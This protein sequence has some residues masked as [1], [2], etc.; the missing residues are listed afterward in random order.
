MPVI[1]SNL[2]SVGY[3]PTTQTLEIEPLNGTIYQYLGVRYQSI[4]A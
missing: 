2:A 1:A 3:E 4:L